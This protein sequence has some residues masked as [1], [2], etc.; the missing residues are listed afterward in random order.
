MEIFF[1]CKFFLQVVNSSS[2]EKAKTALCGTGAD[3]CGVKA[4]AARW[5]YVTSVEPL[6]SSIAMKFLDAVGESIYT[7]P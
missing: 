6:T 4:A 2:I 3:N 5:P 7:R 1:R